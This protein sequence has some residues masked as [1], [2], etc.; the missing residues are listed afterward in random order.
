MT[1]EDEDIPNVNGNPLSNHGRPR[2]NAVE[3]DQEMQ[4][5]RNIRDVCMPMKLVHEVLD[6]AGRLEG[7]QKKE[8]NTK[9]QEKCFCQ[10]HGSTTG[11]AIQ[12]CQTSLS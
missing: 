8:E 6:K 7:Y 2:V 1:F 9:D 5:K 3:S 4:V 10:Y 12:E 11:H